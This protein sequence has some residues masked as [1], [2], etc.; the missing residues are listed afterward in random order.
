MRAGSG[1]GGH[2]DALGNN[3]IPNQ[4]YQQHQQQQF[5]N[6]R[7]PNGNPNEEQKYQP[8]MQSPTTSD[9]PLGSPL[10]NIPLQ[11]QLTEG[12]Y[13]YRSGFQLA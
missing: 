2:H 9:N 5:G 12:R 4:N 13:C 8:G 7:S 3:S 11:V 10:T 6:A 1:S